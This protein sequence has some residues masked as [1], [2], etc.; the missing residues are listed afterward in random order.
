MI[1]TDWQD[2]EKLVFFHHLVPNLNEAIYLA[3][4]AGVDMSMVPSD[5]SFGDGLYQLVTSGRIPE[6]RIDESVERILQ[7]KEDLGLFGTNYY[8][9]NQTLINSVG[10][11]WD[12]SIEIA[13]QS[14]TLLKNQNNILPITNA[15]SRILVT[16]PAGNSLSALAGG[17]SIHVCFLT[18]FFFLQDFNFF[19]SKIQW[20]GAE[21]YEFPHGT[22]IYQGISQLASPNTQVIWNIGVNFTNV[23]DIQ[24]ATN[25]AASCDLIVICLGEAAE[26][27]TPGDINDLSLSAPQL[28]LYTAMENL[29]IPIVLV[30]VE[31]RPRILGPAANAD[32][33]LMTYLPSPIGG[34]VVAEILFGLVSP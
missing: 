2:I 25:D 16:G 14:I 23:I 4:E 17:W 9:T 6:A 22:T 5:Y 33:I 18:L 31:A 32:A 21:D 26:A 10:G 24:S 3:I 12:I 28:E 34:K 8:P 7:L 19:P 29:G 15:P 11:D 13:R 20:Q 27:E 30:L 1:V